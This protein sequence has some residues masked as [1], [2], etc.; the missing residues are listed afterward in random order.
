LD[1]FQIDKGVSMRLSIT[2]DYLTSQGCPEPYLRR[3]ADAGF[4]HVHWAYHFNTD[5]IYSR[6]EVDRID[7]WLKEYGLVLLDLHASSGVEKKYYSPREYERLAGV[8]LVKNRIEMAARLNSGVVILHVPGEPPEETERILFGSQVRKS[9]DALQVYAGN[10]GVK[11]ALENLNKRNFLYIQKLFSEYGPDFLGFCYDSGHG[12]LYDK[13]FTD[14][15]SVKDRLISIHLHDNDGLSDQHKP[16][17]SG[18]VD[19]EGLAAVIARSAYDKCVSMELMTANAEFDSEEAFLKNAYQ[20][21]LRFTEML[22]SKR[23]KTGGNGYA[24]NMR[25]DTPGKGVS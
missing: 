20:D 9:L 19:W 21:G 13:A 24:S 3:I 22:A 8:A 11:I 17:F 18:T 6:Y 14:L 25:H 16:L 7:A 4:S 2:A 12:N 10:M 15:K 1:L 5:F 23:K